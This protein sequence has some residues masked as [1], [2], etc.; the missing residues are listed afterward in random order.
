MRALALVLLAGC[1]PALRPA[2]ASCALPSAREVL[3]VE[4]PAPGEQHWVAVFP[5]APWVF[6][7]ARPSPEAEALRAHVIEKLGVFPSQRELLTRQVA[8]LRAGAP[9]D[10]ANG[11]LLLSGKG[12]TLAP[13]SCLEALAWRAQAQR[14]SMVTH[15]TEF[16]AFVTRGRGEVHLIVSSLDRTGQKLRP[17]VVARVEADRAAGMS[18]LAHLH[19]HLF[20]FDRTIGDR[21]YT[22][23][24]TLHDVGGG[25]APSSTDAQFYRNQTDLALE[26]AWVTNG[27]ETSHW[28]VAQREGLVAPP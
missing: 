7:P 24:A 20:M 28:T 12:G 22:T 11:E 27:F 25:V 21:F 19:N 15:G 5:D 23:E 16:A 10:A 2:E 18:V 26:E 1:H 4:S 13:I 6:E 9:R 17:E 8:Q 3:E 14:W